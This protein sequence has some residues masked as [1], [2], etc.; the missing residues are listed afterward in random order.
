MFL[1]NFL[2][3]KNW[4]KFSENPKSNIYADENVWAFVIEG[5]FNLYK[6]P[7]IIVTSTF[8]KNTELIEDAGC[9]GDKNKYLNYP[10]LGE[11]IFFRNKQVNGQYLSE[12][13]DTLKKINSYKQNMEPFLIVSSVSSLINLMPKNL[14]DSLSDFSIFKGNQYKMGSLTESL[15]NLGYERV[16]KVYDKGEFSIRGDVVDIF[17][18]SESNPLRL[19]FFDDNLEHLNYYDILSQ[20][21]FSEISEFTLTPNFNPWKIRESKEVLLKADEYVKR[22]EYISLIDLLKEK[23][24][25]FGIIICDPLEV[26]LKVK[27]EIDIVEKTISSEGEDLIVNDTEFIKKYIPKRN[28]LENNVT[29]VKFN[30]LSSRKELL[31]ENDFEFTAIKTQKQN[32]GNPGAFIENLK[33]D[34]NKNK[35]ILISLENNERIKKIRE[36]L[37]ETG[38]PFDLL[39]SD[40][41]VDIAAIKNKIISLLNINFTEGMNLILFQFMENLIYMNSSMLIKKQILSCFQKA[42][43]N[44]SPEILLFIR[45]TASEDILM[46]FLKISLV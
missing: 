18:I 15:T 10:Y 46:L 3:E 19:D 5:I 42:L 40:K 33:S 43:M 39:G 30:L 21:N 16:H 20:K 35:K 26:Y 38:L 12:R 29:E 6:I 36:L 1:S 17:D 8:D 32:F 27:S 11:G 4:Q 22:E 41:H 28:F 31:D 37:V 24:G 23:V 7:F 45:H 2:K 14:T 44:L 25:K 34:I 13:L 9:I